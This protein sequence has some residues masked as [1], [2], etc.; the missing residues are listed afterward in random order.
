VPHR[1]E[2]GSS[3][4][5]ARAHPGRY[6]TQAGRLHDIDDQRDAEHRHQAPMRARQL[7]IFRRRD[8]G[9]RPGMMQGRL[10]RQETVSGNHG[11]DHDQGHAR[12]HA[13]VHR[14]SGQHITHVARHHEHRQMQ[15]DTDGDD[16]GAKQK[17][18]A[19]APVVEH[20]KAV[21][22]FTHR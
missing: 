7:G 3:A 16:E 1:A 4:T 10:L 5:V 11:A 12:Q 22:E 14:H 17:C 6:K 19:A 9:D 2:K 20:E 15:P 18:G 8:G 21:G 13:R